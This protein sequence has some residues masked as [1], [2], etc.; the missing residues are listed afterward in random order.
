[1]LAVWS[2]DGEKI[3]YTSM[4]DG[5]AE[6]YIMDADGGNQRN[7]TKHPSLDSSPQW[8]PDST[9][10]V[11]VSN[12]EKI[13][14]VYVMKLTD[15]KITRISHGENGGA[16]GPLWSP[17]GCYIVYQER[18]VDSKGINLVRVLPD[19]TEPTKLTDN[20]K[21]AELQFSFTSDGKQIA[22]A[23]L[24]NKMINIYKMNMDGT[25]EI[26]L[27]NTE[28]SNNSYP[29]WSP[30]GKAILFLSQRDDG[31]RNQ[32]YVMDADGGKQRNVSQ[33]GSEDSSPAWGGNNLITY[34]S[35]KE[36]HFSG[37]LAS[38]QN[39]K[40]ARI[41]SLKGEH[42]QPLVSPKDSKRMTMN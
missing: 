2:P 23:S 13:E 39:M 35:F 29:S 37:Y 4:Q 42:M 14:N 16:L 34:T 30:D 15:G 40:A 20:K 24:R 26:Q 28:A 31:I 1:M 38:M 10:I 7:L 27:T 25:G 5:N 22:F 8:S 41:S 21:Y 32:V 6:I 9:Q 12:R 11:F 33:S 19:G 18:I 3:A 36:G 17:D